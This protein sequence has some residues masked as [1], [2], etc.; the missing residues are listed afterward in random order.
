MPKMNEVQ[1]PYILPYYKK[2]EKFLYLYISIYDVSLND[3]W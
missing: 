1:V 2:S 3:Y